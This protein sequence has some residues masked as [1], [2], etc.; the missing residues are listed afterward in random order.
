MLAP[1]VWKYNY[2]SSRVMAESD[3]RHVRGNESDAAPTSTC[4]RPRKAR[5]CPRAHRRQSCQTG[6]TG[7]VATR[8][9]ANPAKRETT[10][11][12]LASHSRRTRSARE[13]FRC[14]VRGPCRDVRS[15][16]RCWNRSANRLASVPSAGSNFTPASSARISIPQAVLNVRSPSPKEFL[17]RT[18]V[19]IARSTP[20]A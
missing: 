3:A 16:E 5:Q 13:Q 1:G 10:R 9:A 7:S 18:S 8:T 14:R 19:T 11:R 6:S 2:V 17:A 12:D 20:C 15:A 4:R